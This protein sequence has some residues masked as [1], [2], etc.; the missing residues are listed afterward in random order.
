MMKYVLFLEV[1]A[2]PG[3]PEHVVCVLTRLPWASHLLGDTYFYICK[4]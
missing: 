1:D 2:V 3:S 4:I